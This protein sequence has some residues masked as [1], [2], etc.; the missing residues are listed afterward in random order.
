MTQQAN[1]ALAGTL[2]SS[3]VEGAGIVARRLATGMGARIV[4]ILT[5][6]GNAWSAAS[7]YED[8]SRLSD[9]ELERRGIS[10]G[11]LGRCVFE[12]MTEYG[13]SND[14]GIA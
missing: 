14:T 9:A 13:S 5:I 10:R 4:E 7:M 12:A 2:I 3:A 11:E 8:L 1:P 6:C